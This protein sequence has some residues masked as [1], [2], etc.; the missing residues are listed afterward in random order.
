MER[1]EVQAQP[2]GEACP[3][4]GH[5][6]VLRFGR[7]GKFIACSN[8]PPCRYTRPFLVK[9]GVSC[10]KCKQGELV[11]R[12][13]R[14]GRTFYGCERYPE[15]DF[16]VWQRPVVT[17]CPDC[18]GLVLQA[19]K[20]RAKC[21]VCGHSFDLKRLEVRPERCRERTVNHVRCFGA[22][23]HLS[24]RR[25]QRVAVYLAQLSHGDWPVHRVCA[26]PRRQVVGSGGQGARAALAGGAA[27]RRLCPGQHRPPHVG[28]AFLLYVS[29]A[30]GSAGAKR[31][32][33]HGVPKA[34]APAAS[35][36]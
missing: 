31:S 15:C 9:T 35:A 36:C 30:R 13:S 26:G 10:P 23:R 6:L 28:G 29:G 14:K 4:C 20:D 34:A 21:T 24:D 33:R 32:G 1:A 19:G 11:E 27:S 25:A 12:R 8:Y 17:P 16:V 18:G 3:Q 5:D 7:F 22:L 2:I